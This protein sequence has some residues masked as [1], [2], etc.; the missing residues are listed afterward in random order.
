MRAVVL[1]TLLSVTILAAASPSRAQDVD[2]GRQIFEMC[3]ACHIKDGPGPIL[4]GIYDRKIGSVDGFEYSEALTQANEKAQLWT[5]K[6]LDQFLAAPQTYLPDN[7]MAFGA[8]TDAKER[9]DL[10]AFLKTLK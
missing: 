3:L 4:N 5:D 6:A 1:T 7:K 8:V 9:K 10:I 2:N